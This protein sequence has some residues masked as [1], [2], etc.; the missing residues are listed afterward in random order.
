[1]AACELLQL[2]IT[3]KKLLTAQHFCFPKPL[4]NYLGISSSDMENEE[5]LLSACQGAAFGKSS[6]TAVML[7]VSEQSHGPAEL[8]VLLPA[9]QRTS[10]LP[11]KA[12]ARSGSFVPE[13]QERSSPAPPPPRLFLPA[14]CSRHLPSAKTVEKL[15][16]DL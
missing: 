15:G 6:P 11:A 12:T 16:T 7:H 9:G 10:S 3:G 13:L 14:T 8:A 4:M 5:P 1:M 2:C